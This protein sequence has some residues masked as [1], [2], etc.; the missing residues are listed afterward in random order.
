ML[1]DFTNVDGRLLSRPETKQQEDLDRVVRKNKPVRVIEL[2]KDMVHLGQQ[3]DWCEDYIQWL[4]AIET[5]N[6]WEAV[7]VLDDTGKELSRTI[8]PSKPTEPIRPAQ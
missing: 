4:N 6:R 3:W 2:F 8:R 1:T 5:W 7:I